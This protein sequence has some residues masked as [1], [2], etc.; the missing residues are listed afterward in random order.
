MKMKEVC[1]RT[2]LTERTI[3]YYVEEGLIEPH[4]TVSGGREYRDYSEK[5]V[6]DLHAIA[7]LRKLFFTIDEIKDMRRE[8][9]KIGEVL[10]AYKLKL[11]SDAKAKAAIVA[12]LD[13]IDIRELRDA[14]MVADRLKRLADGLPLPQRDIH[15][16]FGRFESGTKADREREYERFAERQARQY[17][18]GKIYIVTI[19]SLNIAMELLGSVVQFDLFSLIIQTALSIAL[20]A[21][22]S[23]VRYLFAVGAALSVLLNA[24]LLF[25]Y[26]ADIPAAWTV[27]TIGHMIYSAAACVLLFKSEAIGEFMYKQRNG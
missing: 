6:Q 24:A 2:G 13:E 9:E 8:P 16:N 5:D 25:N 7:G 12:A 21:G 1:K 15:P 17:R 11:A 23:W 20:L 22:V 4:T 10:A 14:G 27:V 3:R 19:A 26:A 18:L